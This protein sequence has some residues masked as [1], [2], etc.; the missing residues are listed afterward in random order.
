[1]G[2]RGN[3]VLPIRRL[4]TQHPLP[5]IRSFFVG[6]WLLLSALIPTTGLFAQEAEDPFADPFA[7]E[8]S[9]TPTLDDP[10]G[11]PFENSEND[12][13]TFLTDDP[14]GTDPRGSIEFSP[15]GRL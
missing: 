5:S 14:P 6:G 15:N 9:P 12:S 10:F 4:S 13:A 8:S 3:S 11:D 1:M 2:Q 7:E